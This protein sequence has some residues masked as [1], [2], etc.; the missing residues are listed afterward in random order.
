[1]SEKELLYVE[2]ALGHAQFLNTLAA[3][4]ANDLTDGELKEKAGEVC[5]RMKDIFE[6]FMGLI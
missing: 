2:D 5:C 1:M 6:G 3:A 4:A